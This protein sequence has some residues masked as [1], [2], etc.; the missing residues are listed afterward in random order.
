MGIQALTDE[1]LYRAT[2]SGRGSI[3]IGLEKNGSPMSNYVW[4]TSLSHADYLQAKSF[5]S[6]VKSSTRDAAR[7]VTMDISR[8]TRDVIASNESLQREHIELLIASTDRTVGT[9][10]DG[11]ERI[12]Y[13]MDGGFDWQSDGISEL[14]ATFHWGSGTVLASIGHIND[15]LS[16]L[17]KIAKTPVQTAAF[18][19]FEIARNAFHQGRYRESL[20]EL[21][22][23]ISGD[24]TSAGYKREWRFHQLKGCLL[25]TSPSPRDS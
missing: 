12:S 8:Q 16:E 11:F 5:V 15:M 6:D 19:H 21:D 4:G 23:A 7:K 3:P 22:R 1:S 20:E 17:V 9:L 25:Y 24:H 2:Q 13:S 18:N 14:N 10:S